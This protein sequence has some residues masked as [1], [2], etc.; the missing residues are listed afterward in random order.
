MVISR[1]MGLERFSIWKG[2]WAGWQRQASLAPGLALTRELAIAH[3][4]WLLHVYA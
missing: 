1:R 2:S 3:F 4:R